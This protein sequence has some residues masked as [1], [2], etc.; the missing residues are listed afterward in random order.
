MA[1]HLFSVDQSTD[2][3]DEKQNDRKTWVV[4]FAPEWPFNEGATN[5]NTEIV[6]FVGT[7]AQP[8]A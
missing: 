8:R 5:R 4:I 3:L 2:R 6:T 1:V 7:Y